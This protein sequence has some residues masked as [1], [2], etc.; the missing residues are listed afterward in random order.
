LVLTVSEF[1]V[2]LTSV[3]ETLFENGV[4]FPMPNF[5]SVWGNLSRQ[6]VFSGKKLLVVGTSPQGE[7]PLPNSGEKTTTVVFS[8]PLVGGTLPPKR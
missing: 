2:P 7:T 3:S 1:K 8:P 5:P 4:L 6:L